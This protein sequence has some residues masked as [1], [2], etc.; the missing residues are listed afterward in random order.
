LVVA[1]SFASS[2][3]G[4]GLIDFFVFLDVRCSRCGV[5]GLAQKMELNTMRTKSVMKLRAI[6][7]C[8]VCLLTTPLFARLSTDVIV[9]KNGDHLTGEIKGLNTGILYV[10]MK[11]ILGTSS[12]Q[13]SDVAR[14]ES[15][16]LFI[17][18]KDD[19]TVYTGTLSTATTPG[20]KIVQI[21]VAPVSGKEVVIERPRI[22]TMDVTSEKFFQR[23]NGAINIGSTYSKGNQSSQFSLGSQVNYPRERWTAAANFNSTLTTNSGSSASAR[24]QVDVDAFRLL[25]W[26]NWFYEG[27]GTLLQS[28]EQTINTQTTLGAGVGRFVKNTNQAR[29]SLLGGIAQQNTNYGEN[30]PAQNLT[31]GMVIGTVQFFRFNK[32]NLNFSGAFLP[33]FN[34]PGRTKFNMNATYMLKF[35]GNFTW[36]VSFYGN[37][38]SKPPAGFS[39]SDYGST[40]GLSWTFGNK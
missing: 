37:W 25:R 31:S 1:L 36:N 8:C 30:V 33:I 29:I 16:Q 17:V 11:Y 24:N 39:S 19:G 21:E 7:L 23:F 20:D 4:G 9:M 14:V 26:N 32:T 6:F 40:S 15:T 13:W 18:K 3:S 28:S 22:V 27:I 34:D 35:Y 5:D 12:V 38:D 2:C 10:S